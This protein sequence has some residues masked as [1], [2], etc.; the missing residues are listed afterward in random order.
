M[1]AEIEQAYNDANSAL[2]MLKKVYKDHIKALEN[3]AEAEANLESMIAFVTNE[4]D[5]TSTSKAALDGMVK[6]DPR[7]LEAKATVKSAVV[8]VK[9]EECRISWLEKKHDLEKKRMS[10]EMEEA[11]RLDF[12]K[13]T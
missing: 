2:A 12:N 1:Q 13:M 3:K 6:G 5:N 11:K 8:R 9:S 10:A 4:L 7:V